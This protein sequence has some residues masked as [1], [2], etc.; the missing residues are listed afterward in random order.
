MAETIACPS[1]GASNALP[2]AAAPFFCSGCNAIVDPRKGAGASAP[3]TSGSLDATS[4]AARMASTAATPTGY[5]SRYGTAMPRDLAG[6]AG[7]P[8]VG[9]SLLAGLLFAAAGGIGLAA[10]LGWLGEHFVKAPIVFPLLV[11][12]AIRRL[13]ALGGGGGTPDRGVVGS[14]VLLAIAVAACLALRWTEYRG[15]VSRET[16]AVTEAFGMGAAAATA[17]PDLAI[18]NLR[19]KDTDA[20]G[21]VTLLDGRELSVEAEKERLANA[22][23]TGR[24]PADGYDLEMLATEG[25]SGLS[26]HFSYAIH[27]GLS[28][29]FVASGQGVRVPGFGV[30][31]LWLLE[32]ILLLVGSFLRVD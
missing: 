26:G 18:D 4:L 24:V 7:G 31:A 32:T 20:D 12:W 16:A 5:T 2:Q 8:S 27:E 13:L 1:C 3:R 11:A 22:R 14:I 21:S 30:A 29:R 25:V 23:A 6:P 19:R 15:V 17:D 10:G 9:G 28:L